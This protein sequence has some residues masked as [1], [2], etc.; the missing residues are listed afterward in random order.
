M[1]TVFVSDCEITENKLRR[2]IFPKIFLALFTFIATF[3]GDK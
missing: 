2:R 1:D 3:V